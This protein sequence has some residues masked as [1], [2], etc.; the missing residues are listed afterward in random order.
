[1]TATERDRL[2]E[3]IRN[4]KPGSKV[5]AAKEFGIDLTLNF[6]NL[7]LSPTQRLREM[8]DFSRSLE[9]LRRGTHD[10]QPMT[11]LARSLRALVENGAE[12]VV[13][14]AIAGAVHGSEQTATRDLDVCYER[15]PQNLERLV[16]AL[17]PYHPRLRGTPETPAWAF[18]VRGLRNGMNF[19]LATDLAPIDLLG[20][21]TG[22]GQFPEVRAGSTEMELFG[23]KCRVASLKT[24]IASKRAAGR[25]KDLLVLPE[26]E[27]LLEMNPKEE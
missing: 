11:Q 20:E 17:A 22:V 23:I 7:Q 21:V 13:I 1:M 9:A 8:E 16:A 19:T 18:D 24:L 12:F 2:L 5:A 14:G 6:E 4:P 27:A 3:M 15:S 26:L 10:V 25:A